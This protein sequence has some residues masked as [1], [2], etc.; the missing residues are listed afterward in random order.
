MSP[1]KTRRALI[2]KFGAIGDVVMAIPAAF[3]LHQQGFAIDWICGAEVEPV[4]G[5]YPW[6]QTLVADDRTLM[7]GGIASRF[8]VLLSL[9]RLTWLKQYDLC[10]TLYYDSRY[11]LITLPV[12]ARRKLVLSQTDRHRQLL[13]GR[14]HTDEYARILLGWP[15]EER[16]HSLAPIPVERL[17]IAPRLQRTD[18]PRIILVPGGARNMLRDDALRRWPAENYVALA[19]ALIACDYEVILVGGPDDRWSIPFFQEVEVTDCIGQL[20]LVET[21]GL[22]DTADVTVTHDTGPLHLAGITSSGIV[23]IFGPTDPHSRLPQRPGAVALWGGEHF[24][25]RPCYDGRD[26]APCR[27]N[28]CVRE[29]SVAMVSREVEALLAQQRQ[30]SLAPARVLALDSVNV[31][32]RNSLNAG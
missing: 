9:W 10:A 19:R 8:G 13:A 15:D 2:V 3:L 4:L 11:R 30:G 24:A 27:H 31:A 18:R 29:V 26:Y 7:T 23:A 25:C 16:P 12:R 1:G 22:M 17:Q 14:H 5:L 21:I 6:I 20:S 28:G 32:L